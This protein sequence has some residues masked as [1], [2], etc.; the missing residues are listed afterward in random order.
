M[1]RAIRARRG[2]AISELGDLMSKTNNL[3]VASLATDE[4]PESDRVA[5]WREYCCQTA[6]GI[7]IAPD[8]S[9]P[10]RACVSSITVPGLQLLHG[11]MSPAVITR[12]AAHL[13]RE[14]LPRDAAAQDED[15]TGEAGTVIDRR[16]AALA[17]S[18][19]VAR[20]L[21]A[22]GSDGMQR[23]I[24]TGTKRLRGSLARTAEGACSFTKPG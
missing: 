9:T 8:N 22:H 6:Y 2:V 18:G 24:A 13:Q 15:D 21:P 17:G 12:T 16:S 4:L 11:N 19:L 1:P 14:H 23:P 3:V 7:E 20:A 5:L 10:F